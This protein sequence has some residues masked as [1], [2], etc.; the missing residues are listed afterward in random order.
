ML[1]ADHLEHRRAEGDEGAVER[2]QVD[3]DALEAA[4]LERV[5][6]HLGVEADAQDVVEVLA[7]HL[8]HVEQGLL[9]PRHPRHR[10][11]RRQPVD[12][13]QLREVVAGAGRDAAEGDACGA[14]GGEGRLQQAVGGLVDGPVAAGAD[15][16]CDAPSR[17]LPG[18]AERVAG[19]GGLHQL[20][21]HARV[22]QA[23]LDAVP[24]PRALAAAGGR[25]EDDEG[26]H[27][28]GRMGEARYTGDGDDG[29][30]PHPSAGRP[31][32]RA[33]GAGEEW[34][35]RVGIEPTRARRARPSQ[36]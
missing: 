13:D 4:D 19:A 10:R 18:D 22:P 12:V 9:G 5:P 28:M 32:G 11:L 27:K 29:N 3:H 31:R 8:P 2:R 17:R 36:F 26:A 23:L 21:L 6:H 34:R 20:A 1:G 35:E 7:L 15:Q 14:V 30:A 24:Q 33:A 16:F 25:I